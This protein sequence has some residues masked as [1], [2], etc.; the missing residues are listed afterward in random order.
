MNW[1]KTFNC[2]LIG[3]N[4]FLCVS[5]SSVELSD[6]N[7]S[8]DMAVTPAPVSTLK[9]TL[10]LPSGSTAFHANLFAPFIESRIVHQYL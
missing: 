3:P 6:L 1:S 10:I 5:L 9:R 2:S 8:S 4:S 7:F